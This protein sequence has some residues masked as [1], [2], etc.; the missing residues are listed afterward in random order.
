[1]DYNSGLSSLVYN[2]VDCES[3]ETVVMADGDYFTL[4]C[5]NYHRKRD[6]RYIKWKKLVRIR[7][8]IEI[9]S[10]LCGY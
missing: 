7:S 2:I 9:A 5:Q 6:E 8:Y 3:E 10:L 4:E 1:M